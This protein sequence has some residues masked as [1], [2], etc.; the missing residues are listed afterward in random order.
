LKILRRRGVKSPRNRRDSVEEVPNHLG[1][2][3]AAARERERE[4]ERGERFCKV[5]VRRGTQPPYIYRLKHE[6]RT[7]PGHRSDM[8]GENYFNSSEN[9]LKN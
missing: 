4:R 7:C 5:R 1:G 8:S 2:A 9:C 6:T 3:L